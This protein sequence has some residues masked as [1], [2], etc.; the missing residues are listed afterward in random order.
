MKACT[1]FSAWVSFVL[2]MFER[3]RPDRLYTVCALRNCSHWTY[4]TL[5]QMEGGFFKTEKCLHTHRKNVRGG[6]SSLIAVCQNRCLFD[7]FKP[8]SS[9]KIYRLVWISSTPQRERLAV[10][11]ERWKRERERESASKLLSLKTCSYAS[12]SFPFPATF[13]RNSSGSIFIGVL[14]HLFFP[15]FL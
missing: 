2:D 5:I 15:P 7:R 4:A 8:G 14:N 3:S 6:N 13:Q 11:S 1:S 9:A 10:T 12:L